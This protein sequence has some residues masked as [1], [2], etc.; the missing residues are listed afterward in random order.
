MGHLSAMKPGR[1]NHATGCVGT[2]HFY[3]RLR[4]LIKPRNESHPPPSLTPAPLTAAIWREHTLPAITL[5][6]SENRK[7]ISN[8]KQ[9]CIYDL[10]SSI[11]RSEEW[12]RQLEVKYH[13]PRNGRAAERL[14]SA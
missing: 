1:A 12:R 4:V 13:D 2:W 10:N 5:A 14:R 11:L 8:N 3:S 9:N 6:I 7:M